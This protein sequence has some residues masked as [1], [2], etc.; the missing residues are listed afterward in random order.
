MNLS[1]NPTERL[2]GL[3]ALIMFFV[4]MVLVRSEVQVAENTNGAIRTVSYESQIKEESPALAFLTG[5][6]LKSRL[7]SKL[8]PKSPL[9]R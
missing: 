7:R 5:D 3:I 1:I 6:L 2:I 8:D 9:P 4:G